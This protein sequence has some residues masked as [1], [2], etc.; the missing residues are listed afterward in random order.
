M[1]ELR[2][3]IISA[4]PQ[5]E[6]DFPLEF[7]DKVE[8]SVVD[9]LKRSR[10]QLYSGT[11]GFL[12]GQNAQ[13]ILDFTW[14]K[15][16]TGTWRDVAKEWRHVYSYGCLFKVASL[17]LEDPSPTIIQEAIRTCDMGLLMGSAILDNILQRFVNILQNEARKR[18]FIEEDLSKQVITKKMKS[19]CLSMPLVKPTMA[20]PRRHCPSLESFNTNYLLPQAPVILEGTI[21]HW[22]AFKDQP[23]SIE[24]LQTVAGCR[25]VPVEVGSR[26]TD[27]E[28]SQKLLTVNQFIEQ[29]I[30]VKDDGKGLG[31]L[32][33]HQLFEQVPELKK[34]I[35]IPDYC[36]LGEG[37][38]DDITINAWFGPGGTVSPLHQDPQ[39]NFLAQVVGRKYIR[40]YSPEHTDKLYPHESPL[41]HNTSQVDVE[42]PDMRQFPEFSKTPYLE[43]ILQP[44]DV[45]FIPVKYWHYVRSLELSFSV[46]FWWS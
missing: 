43:C 8:S 16:N 17:C 19:E 15:L 41:L 31:Y 28:W 36:S 18:H 35:R 25:T 33:Q 14:E 12:S 42:N 21:D 10:Q 13:I 20:V 7:S 46:S 37:D 22:P 38:E 23:W 32:A 24:Y 30:L 45:L 3:T 34:D 39:Q 27:E 1:A 2:S 6:A 5:S 44:G 40:L 9:L 11:K 4:L 29:Y 26:Y